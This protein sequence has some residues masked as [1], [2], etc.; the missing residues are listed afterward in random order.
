MSYFLFLLPAFLHW[1]DFQCKTDR[2]GYEGHP[3]LFSNAPSS[4]PMSL[5]VHL[6]R[7]WSW[8][9]SGY[10]LCDNAWALASPQHLFVLDTVHTLDSPLCPGSRG[11]GGLTHHAP[12]IHTIPYI[13][14][15]SNSNPGRREMLPSLPL[16][17]WE[18]LRLLGAKFLAKEASAKSQDLTPGPFAPVTPH[19]RP[20]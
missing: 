18:N 14:F 13:S 12:T 2:S 7:V 16:D 20:P 19:S 6:K 9:V 5:S 15:T 4:F 10:L 11:E 8:K 3:Y 1:S 17:R